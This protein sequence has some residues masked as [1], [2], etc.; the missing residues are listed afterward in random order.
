MG[1]IDETLGESGLREYPLSVSQI[2]TGAL[3]L[4]IICEYGSVYNPQ[5]ET[6]A[7]A[8]QSILIFMAL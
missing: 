3:F 1:I 8:T 5:S 2:Y 6:D 7:G 4:G